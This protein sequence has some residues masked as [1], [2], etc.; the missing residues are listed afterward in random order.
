MRSATDKTCSAQELFP[1]GLISTVQRGYQQ[2]FRDEAALG[3]LAQ[4][5][6]AG[7]VLG[8]LLLCK[9]LSNV[10]FFFFFF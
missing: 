8:L 7:I 1:L 3:P 4:N 10:L 9:S 5:I 6:R 2:G